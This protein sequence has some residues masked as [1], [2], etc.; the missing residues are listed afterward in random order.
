MALKNFFFRENWLENEVAGLKMDLHFGP[1]GPN[2]EFRNRIL[3]NFQ[4]FRKVEGK[5]L[6]SMSLKN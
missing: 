2:M 3:F 5:L 4:S 1:K 6:P